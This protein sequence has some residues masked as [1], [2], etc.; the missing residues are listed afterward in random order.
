MLIC[1]VISLVLSL[2][3]RYY[4]IWENN[5]RDRLGH[6]DSGDSVENLDATILDKTDKELS[7]F[8]YVY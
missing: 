2:C 7:Q 6:V 1:F 5:R 4:L 8:R 3:L